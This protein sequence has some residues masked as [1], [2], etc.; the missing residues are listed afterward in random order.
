MFF[1]RNVTYISSLYKYISG[2]K[3]TIKEEISV[4]K[5]TIFEQ[6]YTLISK[7][8]LRAKAIISEEVR[9]KSSN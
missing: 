6:N 4:S 5:Q 8:S 1:C 7:Y 9:I 2:V 3:D